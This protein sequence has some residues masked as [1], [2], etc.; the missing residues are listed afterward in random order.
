MPP[1]DVVSKLKE[2]ASPTLEKLSALTVIELEPDVVC[3]NTG[4]INSSSIVISLP[5]NLP[6]F[7]DVTVFGTAIVKPKPSESIEVIAWV[8]AP[9]EKFIAELKI[10]SPSSNVLIQNHLSLLVVQ[11]KN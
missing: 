6:D 5:P 4:A 1:T 3:I 2:T 7:T 8:P 9:S 10:N 11:Q